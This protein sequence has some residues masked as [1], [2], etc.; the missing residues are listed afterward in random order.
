MRINNNEIHTRKFVLCTP[1]NF[2]ALSLDEIK[3]FYSHVYKI[4]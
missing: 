1:M 4:Q 3:N 2:N